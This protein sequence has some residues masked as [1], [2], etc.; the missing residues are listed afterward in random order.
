MGSRIQSN[1]N[2]IIDSKCPY[3]GWDGECRGMGRLKKGRPHCFDEVT[4]EEFKERL[5]QTE[6]QKIN[7]EEFSLFC[8]LILA[9]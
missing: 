4:D 2:K 5:D 6:E 8:G 9:W 3:E 1:F 7:D